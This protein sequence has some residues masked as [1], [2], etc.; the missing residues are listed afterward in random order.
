MFD[1][2]ENDTSDEKVVLYSGRP[3]WL[4][5]LKDV[6]LLAMVLGAIVYLWP[7]ILSFVAEI[8]VYL[9]NFIIL[10]LTSYVTIALL[11]IVLLIII[12][13][14]WIFLSWRVTEYIVTDSRVI[15]KKGV[16]TRKSHYMPFNRIQDITV[17]QGVIRRLISIGH[18]IV[19]NAY[20][21]TNI[22]FVNVHDPE[23]IQETIFDRINNYYM[24]V[25][26]EEDETFKNKR[27]INER[28]RHVPN[29]NFRNYNDM[30][31]LTQDNYYQR[32]QFNDY[33]YD[34]SNFDDHYKIQNQR[35]N[36][37]NYGQHDKNLF[38]Q[39]N[40]NNNDNLDHNIDGAM[41]NLA[42][43][44]FINEKRRNNNKRNN[45][46]FHSK[47]EHNAHKN[48]TEI[49]RLNKRQKNKKSNKVAK[50]KDNE[51]S[52]VIDIYSRKFK[53]HEK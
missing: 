14:S 38:N 49:P 52:S 6:Y 23:N 13:M 47:L 35:N 19:V 45:N 48:H 41:A 31:N 53:K 43:N 42:N 11:I 33:P 29:N 32:N 24:N 26:T 28:Y 30:N 27:G 4:F 7:I 15:L 3:N 2:D 20:D 34:D 22:D 36:N 12:W 8:Q 37:N 16:F 18:V 21:L 10:P 50:N 40:S 25:K 17:E 51:G 44:Q 39:I 46:N 9:V 1:K 5:A